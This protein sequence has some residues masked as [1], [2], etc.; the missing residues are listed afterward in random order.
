MLTTGGQ[1]RRGCICYDTAAT[2]WVDAKLWNAGVS[3][4]RLPAVN[5]SIRWPELAVADV[6]AAVVARSTR[7]ARRSPSSRLPMRDHLSFGL[8]NVV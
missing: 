2:G 7:P 8:A 1:K 3:S 4:G 5:S 6:L